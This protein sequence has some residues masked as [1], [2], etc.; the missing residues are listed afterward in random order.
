MHSFCQSSGRDPDTTFAWIDLFTVNQNRTQG[1]SQE[2]FIETFKHGVVGT[3]DMLA[4]L[5]ASYKELVYPTRVW[6]LFELW[7]ALHKDVT[8]HMRLT[9]EAFDEFV[10]ALRAG[11][12]AV[13]DVLHEATRVD[14]EAA[15]AREE[16]DR[17]HI[18][19][20]IQEYGFAPINGLINAQILSA[21]CK[22][23]MDEISKA[24]VGFGRIC[25]CCSL[26]L[27]CG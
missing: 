26:V 5:G 17:V 27:I 23:A 19:K 18:L 16:A 9:T 15:Q 10:Q 4:V 14:V 13:V 3:G 25:S 12:G 21:L 22:F 24:E 20:Q 11:D 6:C 2:Y 8:V 7:V 1:Q